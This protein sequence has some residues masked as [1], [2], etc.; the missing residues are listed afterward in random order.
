ME[1]KFWKKK[2]GYIP[3]NKIVTMIVSIVAVT[4]MIG[5]AMQPVI[6]GTAQ[7]IT[8]DL[9]TDESECIPEPTKEPENVGPICRNCTC[10]MEFAIDY[11]ITFV[12][13]N[14]HDGPFLIK[15]GELVG[16]MFLGIIK[17]IDKSGFR[18]KIEPNE[19]ESNISHWIKKLVEPDNYWFNVT[20]ILANLVAIAVGISAYLLSQCEDGSDNTSTI[21]PQKQIIP[22]NLT[23]FHKILSIIFRLFERMH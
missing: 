14:L 7:K 5:V 6:A 2:A 22:P 4:L 1:K 18:I 23:L 15:S 8:P 12:D 9:Q 11:M 10:A 17:G 19:L 20:E 3:N 16:L 21:T 13:R